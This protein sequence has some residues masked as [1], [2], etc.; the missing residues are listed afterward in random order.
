MNKFSPVVYPCVV[1]L[2]AILPS[3]VYGAWFDAAW[4]YRVP[5]NIPASTPVNSTIKVDVDFAALLTSLGV[6]GSFDSNSPRVVR[7]NDALSTIQQFTDS[8]YAG[9]T[10]A[11]NNSRGEIRFI[12]E[13]AGP[14]TYYLYFDVTASGVKPANPQTPINGNFEFG[15]VTAASPQVPPGWL[16][17]T[18]ST[19]T[20]DSRIRPAETV[21]VTDQTTE[22][23][24]GNPNT[25]LASYLQGFRS[26]ADTG[27]NA[28]LTKTITIPATNPGTFSLSIR[29][30]GWDSGQNSNTTQF[31]FLRVRLL[32]GATVLLDIIGPTLNNYATCPFSPNYRAAAITN[33]EP[34]YGRY[35][36]WD[37]GRN[38]NNHT[39]GMP[40]IYDRGL[41]PWI[42]CSANLTAVAGQTV[43]LEIR[44]NYVNQ[45]RSWYLFDD[46]EWS[47]VTATLGTP[48]GNV[49][50]IVPAGF[51]CIEVGDS[52][53]TGRLYT[54]LVGTPFVFDVVALKSDGSVETNYVV[55]TS[56][57]VTVELVNGTGTTAC[58][59]RTAIT[60]AISQTLS[61]L[62]TDQ[63]RK[64]SAAITLGNANSNIRCRVTD[65]NQTPNVLGCSS[66][67]FAARPTNFT[68][69]SSAN[70][71]ATG[72][73][74]SLS[75]IIK[76]GT[77]FTLT[78]A[79]GVVGYNN[80][81]IL[82]GSKVSAHSGAAQIGTLAGSF[83]NAVLATGT[84]IG[85]AFTYSEVGYF[86][87]ATNG[88]FD[89]SF[90]TVDSL[91]GDC[92]TDFSNAL[93]GGKYGC[94][95]GN[96]TATAFFGRFIPDHF[97]ITPTSVTPACSPTFTYFGQ[98]GFST[99]FT[100]TAQNSGNITTRNYQ[101]GFARLDLT[102]WAG[103]NFSPTSAL[104]AGSALS[105]SATAP[106]GTWTQGV[107]DVLAK[108][109]ISRP[110]ALT[111]ETLVTLNAAPVDLD[112]VTLT[113]AAVAPATP[114]RYGR[115]ALQN[116]YG[117]EL[118]DLPMS[119]TTEYWNGT[120]W[121][122]NTDDSCSSGI[123]LSN[124]IITGPITTVCAWDSGSPGSSG[125]GCTTAGTT[126]N[127]FNEP[128]PTTDKGNFNLNLK[129]PGANITG[130]IDIT[131][132][133]PDF[134]KF[135]WQGAGDVNPTARATFG[136]YKGNNSQ[137]YLREVY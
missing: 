61:F 94:N 77:N 106:V 121:I 92:T 120:N 37:N 116:A 119:L 43:T 51:N 36:F 18:R 56:K 112:G 54:K 44:S 83:G 79:S 104:P 27:G 73:S 102:S 8:I 127:M 15:S 11:V 105:A 33:T 2:L 67:S 131:A 97:A 31:D 55:G 74:I 32:N 9:A 78:A 98:D 81:P 132:T 40:T 100:L 76:A 52:P 49:V 70:A 13:D 47:V 68:V 5:V 28:V 65:S 88:V 23:T 137:I 20:M 109:Q 69:T 133:V 30:E 34:G 86:N 124:T 14:A 134:L 17:A 71:D 113:A 39:L 107:A 108:H 25:G 26:S 115:V 128:P 114:L 129:A 101:G 122:K 80:A 91:V 53:S 57:S 12:L 45:Y 117:S 75:P 93:V 87:L 82:D 50:A 7:S 62:T 42:S 6:S 66:D 125:I 96:T 19:N 10:D 3:C 48:S 135:N 103:F 60:P 63:G 4:N 72:V 95:F 46:I 1:L 38:N 110:T 35:N 90:T 24:N 22:V 29:P 16:A 85:S 58:G 123:T 84:A 41:E 99:L 111:G 89:N 136:I 126:A 21:T 118:L 64:T 59:S 130:S